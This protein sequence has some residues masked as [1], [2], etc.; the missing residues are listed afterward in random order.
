MV[1]QFQSIKD[2]ARIGNGIEH[3]SG[4]REFERDYNIP[5]LVE[6][7]TKVG[8]FHGLFQ[9]KKH[10]TPRAVLLLNFQG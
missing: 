6:A 7:A 1:P 8:L 10:K 4:H 9:G 5:E 2:A 3:I